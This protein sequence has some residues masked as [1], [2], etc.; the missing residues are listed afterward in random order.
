MYL[1][2]PFFIE[3][4]IGFYNTMSLNLTKKGKGKSSA[5]CWDL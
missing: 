3:A 4:F 5:S 2:L 1:M